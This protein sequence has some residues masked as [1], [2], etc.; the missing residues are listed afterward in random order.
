MLTGW[1]VAGDEVSGA[2]DTA[3]DDPPVTETA[4]FDGAAPAPISSAAAMR[5]VIVIDD[6]GIRRA[7]L[8]VGMVHSFPRL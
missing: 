4:W 6:K 7:E 1:A 2:A 3:V 5:G 8:V